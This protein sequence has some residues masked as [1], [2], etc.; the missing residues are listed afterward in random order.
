MKLNLLF[1]NNSIDWENMSIDLSDCFDKLQEVIGQSQEDENSRFKPRSFDDMKFSWGEIHELFQENKLEELNAAWFKPI[2]YST[3][4]QI[5]TFPLSENEADNLQELQTE[6]PQDC[7]GLLGCKREQEKFVFDLDSYLALKNECERPK[8]E[9]SANQIQQ[10]INT[11]Y[12]HIFERIDMPTITE[13]G[14]LHGEQI[15]IHLNSDNTKNIGAL[16][17]DGTWKHKPADKYLPIKN[18]AKELL[19]EWGFMLPVE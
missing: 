11:Q 6:F 8:L 1:D 15:Q 2:A 17:I 9:L 5:Y 4:A 10:L 7:N 12:K 19:S 16:N 18:E 3:F 14:N 13:G